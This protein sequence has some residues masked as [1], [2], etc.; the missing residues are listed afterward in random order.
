MITEVAIIG[1][2]GAAA[3]TIID[4]ENLLGNN[5]EKKWFWE[6]PPFVAAKVVTKIVYVQPKVTP[7]SE[8]L[9]QSKYQVTTQ[10]NPGEWTQPK[11]G[12]Y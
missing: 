2:I 6:R 5:P 8:P 3:I 11:R 1:T 7:M 10:T 9:V 4:H 12:T